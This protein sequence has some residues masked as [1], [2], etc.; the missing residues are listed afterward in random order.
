MTRLN[1]TLTRTALTA[2]TLALAAGVA[3]P[4][5]SADTPDRAIYPQSG[6]VWVDPVSP[7][8][9]SA[10]PVAGAAGA[11]KDG[12]L[13]VAGPSTTVAVLSTVQHVVDGP[14]RQAAGIPGSG[15]DVNW[16]ISPDGG[17]VANTT[18]IR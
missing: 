10:L 8:V 6:H 2:S 9:L 13:T 12:L 14:V 16:Q 11:A 15:V 7:Q 5:A 17:A 3:A 4:A 1:R 18:E